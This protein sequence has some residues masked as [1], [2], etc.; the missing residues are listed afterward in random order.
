MIIPVRRRRKS[1]GN[2]QKDLSDRIVKKRKK[3]VI[4]EEMS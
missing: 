4:N 1:E 3:P 2:N